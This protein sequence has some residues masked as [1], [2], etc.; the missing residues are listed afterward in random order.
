MPVLLAIL[1]ALNNHYANKK[2]IKKS[3]FDLSLSEL[4]AADKRM[5]LPL[6]P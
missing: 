3:A 1:E 5:Q 6:Y 4:N 2:A